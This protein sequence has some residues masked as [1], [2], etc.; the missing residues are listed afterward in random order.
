MS[1]SGRRRELANEGVDNRR[2]LV[3]DVGGTFMRAA[4]VDV[5]SGLLLSSGSEL[6]PNYLSH[7]G[8]DL[9][10][11]VEAVIRVVRELGARLLEGALPAVVVV[12]YPGPVADCGKAL[13]APT[14]LGPT[15][16]GEH[17]IG[18][19][20][21]SV[22]ADAEVIVVNDLTCAGFSYVARGHRDFCVVTVGSGIGNKVFI[23][24]MPLLGAKG[25]GGEIGHLRMSLWPDP[26]IGK[27]R[28]EVGNI[29]S[30]RGTVRLA[31][32]W[33][34]SGEDE[35]VS[36][37][38][39]ARAPGLS[40]ALESEDLAEA[41]RAGDELAVRIVDSGCYPLAVAIGCIHLAIGI[42]TFFLVGGFAKALGERYRRLLADKVSEMTWN[43]GQN[44]EEMI[45]LGSAEVEEG[46][47]GATYLAART[48]SAQGR[49][50][51]ARPQDQEERCARDAT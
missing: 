31:R 49:N 41:F 34:A 35:W 38:R 20:L 36:T 32:T 10:G 21:K 37:G 9:A 2:A 15:L 40:V 3:F 27:I 18:C 39:M 25:R 13:R 5:E 44:W 12:G 42:E 28:D 45:F 47:L 14:I 26:P 19:Q 11:L 43:I 6:T 48:C 17:D 4:V 51:V 30:G 7:A 22:W 1:N 33:V 23:D 16:D 8:C 29:A 46:L 50:P 24:G